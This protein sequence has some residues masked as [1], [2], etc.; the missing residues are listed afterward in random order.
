L[1]EEQKEL[2]IKYQNAYVRTCLLY[3]VLK[4]R[5]LKSI[6]PEDYDNSAYNAM[7]AF[8]PILITYLMTQDEE[9]KNQLLTTHKDNNYYTFISTM[10]CNYG[11]F[12]YTDKLLY[13]DLQEVQTEYLEAY[14]I[15]TRLADQVVTVEQSPYLIGD[16]GNGTLDALII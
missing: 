13:M 14:K 7:T 8:S 15:L 5:H 11:H 9:F 12:E 6:D 1:E 4:F 2:K 16:I 3:S 10:L